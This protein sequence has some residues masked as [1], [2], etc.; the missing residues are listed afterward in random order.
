MTAFASDRFV[1]GAPVSSSVAALEIVSGGGVAAE[2]PRVGHTA[3]TSDSAASPQRDLPLAT[4]DFF[5]NSDNSRTLLALP[6]PRGAEASVA[7]SISRAMASSCVAALCPMR[8]ALRSRN[9]VHVADE[10]ALVPGVVLVSVAPNVSQAFLGRALVA[11]LGVAASPVALDA[12]QAALL[13]TLMCDGPCVSV[14]MGVIEGGVLRVTAGPL[15][16]LE[17][18]VRRVDRHKRL[19]WIGFAPEAS[20]AA[21]LGLSSTAG[22]IAVGLEVV[23]KS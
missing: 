3:P 11:A 13:R 21:S 16:G 17:P 12:P 18:L 20:V 9:G 22:Q 6:C 2:A 8:V 10:R 23:A 1:A 15:R 14:S 4:S 5:P 19:A 7:Q